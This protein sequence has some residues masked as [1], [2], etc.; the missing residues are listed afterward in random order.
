MRR[1]IAV[2]V[3]LVFAVAIYLR[4]LTLVFLARDTYLRAIGMRSQ[5]VQVGG[6]RIHY[7]VG[8]EGPPLVVVHGVASRAADGALI[9]RALMRKHRVYALDLLGYGDSDK[10]RDATYTVA[11][12]AE[13]VRGFMDALHLRH[14]DMLGI[15]LGGWIS[16]KVAAEH[17]E[18]VQRLVLVSSAGLAFPT[19]LH[20]SAFSPND[21]DELR[22]SLQRQTDQ[23]GRIP[24]FVLKDFLRRSK[25]KA[26]VVRRSMQAALKRDDLLDR[27]L[28]R[29]TM[30]VLLVWG[31]DDRIVP[32]SVAAAMQREMPHARVV[33]LQGCGHLAIIECRDRAIPAIESFLHEMRR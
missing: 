8:G 28:Q 15:S 6:H 20:E 13:I 31:T 18:R 23:A 19:T 21:L 4:P 5:H 2:L 17:P 25:A 32:F 33:P 16:L 27:K 1:R 22:A 10:P 12:Q 11:M 26:W 30:P 14:A 7:F 24:T 29:V 9:Y 3:L